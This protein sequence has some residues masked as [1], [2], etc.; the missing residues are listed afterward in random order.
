MLKVAGFDTDADGDV[1]P[2]AED[3]NLG[4]HLHVI[5]FPQRLDQSIRST[6]RHFN[7]ACVIFQHEGNRPTLSS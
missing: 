1:I 2:V 3:L 5:S 4:G 6:D 7:G